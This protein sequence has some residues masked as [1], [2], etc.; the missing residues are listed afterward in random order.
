[1][2]AQLIIS[3]RQYKRNNPSTSHCL[4]KITGHGRFKRLKEILEPGDCVTS[5]TNAA[6]YLIVRYYA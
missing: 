4:E 3:A 2:K 5:I 6:D 1:M